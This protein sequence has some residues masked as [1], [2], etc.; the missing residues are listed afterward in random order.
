VA[1]EHRY[2]SSAYFGSIPYIKALCSIRQPCIDEGERFQ[3]QT[4]RSRTTILGGNGILHL[5][6]PVIRPYG[7]KTAMKDILIS[8]EQDWQKDHWKSVESAYRHAPYFEDYS[9]EIKKLIYTKEDLLVTLNRKTL[10]W[11]IEKLDLPILPYAD[12]NCKPIQHASDDRV[13]FNQKTYSLPFQPY[14]QVFSDKFDFIPHLSVLDLLLNEGP[15][16]RKHLF[17]G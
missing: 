16:A 10:N 4:Q 11:I 7:Q 5:S 14:I 3:K 12:Q 8:Y 9:T 13:F 1:L 6:V 15:M 2:F 17:H